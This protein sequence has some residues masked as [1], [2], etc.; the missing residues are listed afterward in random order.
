MSKAFLL[1]SEKRELNTNYQKKAKPE[2]EKAVVALILTLFVVESKYV[3]S[4]ELP[5]PA[6]LR[7]NPLT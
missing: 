1:R 6:L 4:P 7:A 5:E 3:L 2:R